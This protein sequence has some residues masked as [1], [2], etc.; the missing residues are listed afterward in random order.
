METFLKGGTF[1]GC[2]IVV[3][4]NCQLKE[5]GGIEKFFFF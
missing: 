4:N 5:K 1:I 3:I 2:D